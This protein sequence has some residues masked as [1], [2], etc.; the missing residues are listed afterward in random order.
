MRTFQG[1]V[2]PGYMAQG[3]VRLVYRAQELIAPGC[4]AQELA[5]G[6]LDRAGVVYRVQ[7]LVDKVQQWVRVVYTAQVLVDK[8]QGLVGLVHRAQGLIQGSHKVLDQ[9]DVVRR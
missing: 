7:A 1:L 3:H 9:A 4:K 8:V 6:V 2:E 5:R